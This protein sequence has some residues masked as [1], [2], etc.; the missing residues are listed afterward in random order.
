MKNFFYNL[1]PDII[2]RALEQSGLEPT[3]HCMALNSYE[4]RVYDLKLE[5]GTHVVAKFYRPGRWSREQI[6]EEHEFL[7]SLRDDEI[8][9]CAPRGFAD[10]ATLHEIE[11][12][13]YAIWPR[14]GGRVP[15]E[16]SDEVL[17]I[18]GRTLAR[19]HNMGASKNA[20]YRIALTGETYGLKPLAFLQENGFLPPHC[21][22]RY[23][24][25]VHEIVKLYDE[26]RRDVP[27]HRIHGDCH[28][29][30]LL[31]GAEGWY[32]LDFDDFLNGPAVQ[33][34]WMMVPARDREGLRQ[35]EVFL[36]AYGQ[37]REFDRSTLRLIEP[38]RALRYINYA[39]WIARRWEDPAF[40]RAFPHF[41]TVQYWEECTAD[42][43]EQIKYFHETVE[44][45]PEGLRRE[46]DANGKQEEL[47]NKDYFWDW[48]DK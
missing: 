9:V 27:F 28:L 19:I 47:T 25:A 29:G 2:L 16:L 45:I 48:E 4:N 23:A 46:Q 31:H 41:G 11:G 15:D 21:A 8:P 44:D 7:I 20:V 26:L 35:R 18:L 38:L 6:L 30:N 12:I 1:T 34:V 40:P 3:G 13:Y 22:G 42:L 5:D 37:F 32:F 24:D 39:A 36:E 10:G 17:G 43:E 33:D 14:T